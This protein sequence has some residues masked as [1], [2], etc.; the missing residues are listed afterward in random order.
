[1]LQQMVFCAICIAVLTLSAC[2][3]DNPSEPVDPT[4]NSGGTSLDY[5]VKPEE[6]KP[7]ATPESSEQPS[8]PVSDLES[9]K[10]VPKIQFASIA[11]L[12]ARIKF[13]RDYDGKTV[14]LEGVVAKLETFV[15]REEGATPIPSMVICS[16]ADPEKGFSVS[17]VAGTYQVHCSPQVRPWD[18]CQ[19]G[20]TVVVRGTVDAGG[21]FENAT[22]VTSPG[23]GV[24]RFTA[25]EILN[26]HDD[27]SLPKGTLI[28][29]GM[30]E[31]FAEDGENKTYFVVDDRKIA[32]GFTT[33]HM[34][35]LKSPQSVT[36]L[37]AGWLPSFAK[38]VP[39]QIINCQRI[40]ILD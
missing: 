15:P 12:L 20:D 9:G 25:V 11:D 32:M 39:L 24:S 7:P 34:F 4:E 23:K 10:E 30:C 36:V 38:G 35:T 6:L 18:Q 28:V 22:L 13:V 26:S 37:A 27:M 31:Q 1:M 33:D 17:N 40:D 19:A 3:S 14:D 2:S 16:L 29:S 21:Y 8:P 5:T